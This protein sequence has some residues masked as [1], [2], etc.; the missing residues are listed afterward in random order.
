MKSKVLF[1]LVIL[2]L[3]V[4]GLWNCIT[5]NEGSRQESQSNVLLIGVDDLNDWTGYLV[6]IHRLILPIWTALL[7][8]L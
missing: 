8:V 3:I 7:K 2:M 1:L 6:V 5:E 4:T